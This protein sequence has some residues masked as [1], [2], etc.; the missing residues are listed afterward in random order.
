MGGILKNSSEYRAGQKKKA[1]LV[2][3]TKDLVSKGYSAS[4]I[5]EKLKISEATVREY[6]HI[7]ETVEHNKN[8]A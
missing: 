8:Q 5:A 2:G 4:E 3:R 6:I 1:L 7:I